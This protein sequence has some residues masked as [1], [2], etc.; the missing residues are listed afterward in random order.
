[1]EWASKPCRLHL[2]ALNESN[3]VWYG[4]MEKKAATRLEN[5]MS[6]DHHFSVQLKHK[7]RQVLSLSLELEKR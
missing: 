7:C 1:M 4:Q 3:S 2:K 5:V 6:K